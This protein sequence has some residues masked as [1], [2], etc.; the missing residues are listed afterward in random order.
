MKK[1]DYTPKAWFNRQ[2]PQYGK[3]RCELGGLGARQ[4]YVE[5]CFSP[6]LAC[7]LC[8][9]KEVLCNSILQLLFIPCFF[10][11]ST[12]MSLPPG[13]LPWLHPGLNTV[14]RHVHLL[15]APTEEHHTIEQHCDCVSPNGVDILEGRN[16]C[17]T[18]GSSACGPRS[19]IPKFCSIH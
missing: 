7:L 19:S 4:A 17:P 14:V 15:H 6:G 3:V 16:C 8:Y 18:G 10:Q 11:D 5:T 2:C 13:S 9:F 12:L 1:H